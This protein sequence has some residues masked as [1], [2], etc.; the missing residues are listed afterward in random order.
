M[1]IRNLLHA[2]ASH[3]FTTVVLLATGASGTT[4]VFTAG[5][6]DFHDPA[7]W[8]P[9]AVP[10]AG[11]TASVTH[12]SFITVSQDIA[13]A[14]ML[15]ADTTLRPGAPDLAIEGPLTVSGESLPTLTWSAG[16]I[17][18]NSV[19]LFPGAA[20]A[21]VTGAD[22]TLAG[23]SVAAAYKNSHAR[24]FFFTNDGA[25]AAFQ[26]QYFENGALSGKFIKCVKVALTQ[27]PDGIYGRAA[28]ARYAQTFFD[29]TGRID[30]DTAGTENGTNYFASSLTLFRAPELTVAIAPAP[31][32]LIHTNFIT[33]A[34]AL[35]FPGAS[36]ADYRS[37]AALVAGGSFDEDYADAHIFYFVNTGATASFQ[38]Q[39]RDN[40]QHTKCLKIELTQQPDGIH[41]RAVYARYRDRALGY[42]VGFDFDTI[43]VNGTIATSLASAGYGCP[44]FALFPTHAT[45]TYLPAAVPAPLAAGSG[46]TLDR[47]TDLEAYMGGSLVNNRDL[48]TALPFH[49]Q[50]LSP[51]TAAVQFQVSASNATYCVKVELKEDA[52]GLSARALYAKALVFPE[53]TYQDRRG[54]DFD[55]AGDALPLANGPDTADGINIVRLQAVL[56]TA[57]LAAR[58]PAVLPGR[59]TVEDAAF[60]PARLLSARVNLL[61]SSSLL[62]LDAPDYVTLA[63]APTGK[64]ALRIAAPSGA[65]QP[66]VTNPVHDTFLPITPAVATVLTGARLAEITGAA[67]A[68]GGGA[69]N[70]GLGGPVPAAIHHWRAGEDAVTFQAHIFDDVHT[71]CVKVRLTQ[72]GNDIMASCDYAR[73]LSG[74]HLP[75][76]DFDTNPGWTSFTIA[77]D[78]TMGGYGVM[79]IALI[80]GGT[81]PPITVSAG[82][83]FAGPITLERRTAYINVPA[84][85]VPA[86]SSIQARDGATLVAAANRA[87]EGKGLGEGCPLALSGGSVLHVNNT[88]TLGLSRPITLNA[89]ECRLYTGDHGDSGQYANNMT[90]QNGA[91]LIGNR[92]RIGYL[93]TPAH[94]L[95]LGPAAST[96]AAGFTLVNN[97]QN[98][99]F[100][101]ECRADFTVAAQLHDYPEAGRYNQPLIK[102]GAAAMTLAA[103]G[104]TFGGPV[105][106]RS[107]T[108][109]LEA[110]NALAGTNML[111]V[112]ANAELRIAAAQS[113][114]HTVNL[115]T[116][117]VLSLATADAFAGGAALTIDGATVRPESPAAL[118]TAGQTLFAGTS[119]LDFGVTPLTVGAALFAPDATV[120]LIGDLAADTLRFLERLTPAQLGRFATP[121]GRRAWQTADGYL[122]DTAR[123]T[124]FSVQ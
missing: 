23:Q 47:I 48:L 16:A 108:L 119:V 65:P 118:N 34:D 73:Y 67:V 83:A 22:G 15:S 5:T 116:N 94:W 64:G 75:G 105:T 81:P 18:T 21:E 63:A 51:T 9:A 44:A 7:A 72:Q 66:A 56:T 36:L 55:L 27:Q 6:G 58:Q 60:A 42:Q 78:N 86:P 85:S 10:G 88:F 13:A 102:S 70:N 32:P 31:P 124:L 91:R 41:G 35:L 19:L 30:F 53:S 84:I 43:T 57:G 100:I 109:R 59:I 4:N 40:G 114:P 115:S 99:P 106:V 76:F 33:S 50:R 82:L 29:M 12:P 28:Y 123:G 39:R 101:V 68:L 111:T 17:P 110:A 79:S 49:W 104:S 74:R 26:L 62:T 92:I 113:V 20:L 8:S 95:I 25:S 87:A 122:R 37:A 120:T 24:A 14:L 54:I 90:L 103:S 89:S 93:T 1:R 45:S 80:A 97:A 112:L 107:G 52:G 38:L 69:M 117:A 77:T 46:A 61:S 11:D 71:K 121:S 98:T 2:V 96:N 3:S